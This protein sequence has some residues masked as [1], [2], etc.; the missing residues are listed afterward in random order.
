M[1]KMRSSKALFCPYTKAVWFKVTGGRLTSVPHTAKLASWHTLI[2]FDINKVSVYLSVPLACDG[3][4]W[5]VLLGQGEATA[6]QNVLF[7]QVL[8]LQDVYLTL[9]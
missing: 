8:Q 5:G 6:G 7:L 4:R 2:S 1:A 9:H 3:C